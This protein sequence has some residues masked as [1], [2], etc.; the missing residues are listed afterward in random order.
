VLTD[1][2]SDLIKA[3][4][5]S[6]FHRGGDEVVYGCWS[7]DKD[8]IAWMS[9]NGISSYDQLLSYFVVKADAITRSL[10]ATPVH[11]EE[12]FAAGVP[13]EKDTI[14][15]VWTNSSVVS[16]VANAG[17]KVIAAPSDYWY[18]DHLTIPWTTMY[19][20]EPTNGLSKAAASLIIGGEVGMWGEYV[21]EN[22][23]EGVVY[24]RAMAVGERLWSAQTV[25]DTASAKPRLLDQRCRMVQR[26]FRSAPVEPSFCA[27]ELV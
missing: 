23:F 8:I 10:G 2:L 13:L 6:Y 25:M 12:V 9:A 26:G 11:W 20:Y 4:G 1:I 21:D 17:Y 19:T 16:T 5:A 27:L 14:V 22:N 3:S 24:P 7:N 15:E 18:L